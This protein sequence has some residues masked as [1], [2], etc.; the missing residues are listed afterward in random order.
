MCQDYIYPCV[1]SKELTSICSSFQIHQTPDPKDVLSVAGQLCEEVEKRCE[2][3]SIYLQKKNCS[4]FK[5]ISSSKTEGITVCSKGIYFSK[6]FKTVYYPWH[7]FRHVSISV[8]TE[9][10]KLLKTFVISQLS[11]RI[12]RK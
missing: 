7:L 4:S 6:S 9:E 3:G 12:K 2:T 10:L 8:E 1:S 5:Y 11:C